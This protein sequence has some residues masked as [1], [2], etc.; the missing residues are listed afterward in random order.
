M[1]VE[2]R[3]GELNLSVK[4]AAATSGVSRVTWSKILNGH[5]VSPS[6]ATMTAV[7][8]ALGWMPGSCASIWAGGNP[9]KVGDA[10]DG[11]PA[12]DS[13]RGLDEDRARAS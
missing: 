1:L 4:D 11:T 12:L 9:V 3:L 13:L 10:D 2:E 7:D 6:V 8:W 5:V